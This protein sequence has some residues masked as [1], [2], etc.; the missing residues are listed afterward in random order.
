[1]TPRQDLLVMLTIPYAHEARRTEDI[2][3][4][5][6]AG[7]TEEDRISLLKDVLAFCGLP[8]VNDRP[9][10]TDEPHATSQGSQF[11]RGIIQVMIDTNEIDCCAA[12]AS[13]DADEAARAIYHQLDLVDQRVGGAGG[14]GAVL[15]LGFILQNSK[16]TPFT[17]I[18]HTFPPYQKDEAVRAIVAN[19][20]LYA[21]LSMILRTG[22]LLDAARWLTEVPCG[23]IAR[24][25][26]VFYALSWIAAIMD[27]PGS[28][29]VMVPID[30][31]NALQQASPQAMPSTDPRSFN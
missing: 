15:W 20:E 31:M 19:P 13:G 3:A 6:R 28:M 16:H 29:E 4:L 9:P 12:F 5:I 2:L 25:G 21:E 27:Q 11:A 18:V 1:M 10:N 7:S 30:L 17:N 23:K 26:L 8:V 22:N 24:E 14:I